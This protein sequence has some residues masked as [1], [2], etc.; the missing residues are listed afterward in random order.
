MGL[1]TLIKNMAV[2][3]G[4]VVFLIST[5]EA[6][7]Y[8]VNGIGDGSDFSLDGV[9]ELTSGGGECTLRAAIQEANN[10]NN[11]SVITFDPSLA[12]ST[13]LLGSGLPLID[14]SSTR[15][16]MITGPGADLLTID[17]DGTISRIFFVNDSFS[18]DGTL[19]VKI[20]GLTVT[21][22][23]GIS[24]GDCNS[25]LTLE[26]MVV[27]GNTTST[28]EG[29]GVS[30]DGSG[31]SGCCSMAAGSLIIKNSLIEGNST[32]AN[33]GG[34]AGTAGG[35][36]T[37]QNTTIAGNTSSGSGG[38]IFNDGGSSLTIEGSTVFQ[39][40]SHGNSTT[41]DDGGGGL[42]NQ[43]GSSISMTNC[44]ISENDALLDGGGID[45]QGDSS[46]NTITLLNV[47]VFGNFSDSNTSGFGEGGGISQQDG[48]GAFTVTNTIIAGNTDFTGTADDCFTD[49]DDSSNV[50]SGGNNFIG[51]IV[52]CGDN[53]F[54][55]NP[56]TL[57][58]QF[59]DSGSGS[60]IDPMLAALDP[61]DGG[62]PALGGLTGIHLPLVG[63][64]AIDG[65]DE[66][67]ALAPPTDQRGALRPIGSAPDIG[68]VESGCGNNIIEESETCD[69]GASNSDTTP[70]ACRTTCVSPS[71]GDNI[72]D[73]G[74]ACDD[75]G[76]SV[77]CNADCTIKTCGNGV[78]ETPE[79]CDGD[80]AGAGGETATC[81][82]NCTTSACGDGKLNVTAGEQCEDGNTVDG[83]GC[84]STC[85]FDGGPD[86]DGDGIPDFVDTDDDG[87]GIDDADDNCPVDANDDQ[88]D[89]D[90][91]GTGDACDDD[92][93]ADGVADADD[94]CPLDDN[95]DQLDEDGNGVGDACEGGGCS[96]IR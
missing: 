88:T 51:D 52:G 32:T 84:D 34:V 43:G 54:D 40:S 93:D 24:V 80:G 12:G 1:R 47:T 2:G 22:G 44:T 50:I 16:V 63:S 11:D 23:A 13:I 33:G 94:N 7:D 77:V 28:V 26:N 5:A 69:N 10:D 48:A 79:A 14:A 68:A 70:D 46:A 83:D 72:I 82:A 75:G 31:S 74:E 55:D 20:S 53:T 37:I 45:N 62:N 85:Q 17:G 9:C 49:T 86:F 61:S 21:N 29:G 19:T 92:D 87:D 90:D 30:N 4:M 15:T 57:N 25:E 58:D 39:N 78:V 81:N 66:S 38:G 36:V 8:V 27:S 64:T 91:D 95:A 89:T 41:P 59:G 67:I 6:N 35:S 18:C 3:L 65:V 73:S 56:A 76:D 96:L 71:C 42:Y 60:P